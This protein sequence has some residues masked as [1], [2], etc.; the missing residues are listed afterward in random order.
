[1]DIKYI[2]SVSIIELSFLCSVHK[3][4]NSHSPINTATYNLRGIE[5]L[6]LLLL[7]YRTK[8]AKLF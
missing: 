3:I 2:I 6:S 8:K 5:T 1:M 7:H 4:K